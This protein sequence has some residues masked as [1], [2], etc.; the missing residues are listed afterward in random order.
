MLGQ[1]STCNVAI[2]A[3]RGTIHITQKVYQLES[4]SSSIKL[5]F[6]EL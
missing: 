3:P 5:Y 2:S 4:E 6:T 1:G